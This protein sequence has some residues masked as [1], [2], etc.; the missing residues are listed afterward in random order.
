M[1]KQLPV[2]TM[3]RI[4]LLSVIAFFLMQFSVTLPIF[5]GFLSM[6]ISDIPALVGALVMGPMAGILI[7]LIKNLLDFVITGSNSGGIGQVANFI[8]AVAL[9]TPISV[10]YKKRSNF[11]GYIIGSCIGIVFMVA[12]AA[13]F[14]CFVLIPMYSRIIIPLEAII[15]MAYAINPR[16]HNMRTLIVF[17]IVPFNML[18]GLTIVGIGAL[19]HNGLIVMLRRYSAH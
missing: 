8:V 1:K 18:K 12:V 2:S 5:P 10:I 11:R 4:S 16:V 15:N 14:N 7:S 13:I 6:D 17:S 9:I 3:V 19:L